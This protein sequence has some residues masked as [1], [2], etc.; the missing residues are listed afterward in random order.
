MNE[1][2]EGDNTAISHGQFIGGASLIPGTQF[3]YGG[4][5]NQQMMMAPG[6]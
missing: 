3:N 2:N 6:G 5:Q 4:A 1:M